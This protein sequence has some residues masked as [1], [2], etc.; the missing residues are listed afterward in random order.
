MTVARF[1]RTAVFCVVLAPFAALTGVWCD[2]SGFSRM[3]V[4]FMLF[5][6]I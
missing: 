4:W 3:G 2:E 1:V 5:L 6:V